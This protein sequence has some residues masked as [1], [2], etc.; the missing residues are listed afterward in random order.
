MINNPR[1]KTEYKPICKLYTSH[2]LN[3]AKICEKERKEL[4]IN[5]NM[6]GWKILGDLC[7]FFPASYIYFLVYFT[8]NICGFHNW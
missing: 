8:M 1:L 4:N 6:F 2:Y 5:V 3:Y 7:F